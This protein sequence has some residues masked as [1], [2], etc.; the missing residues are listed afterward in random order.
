MDSVIVF[1]GKVLVLWGGFVPYIVIGGDEHSI[2][3][4]PVAHVN[5]PVHCKPGEQVRGVVRKGDVRQVEVRVWPSDSPVTIKVCYYYCG[6]IIITSIRRIPNKGILK[7][8]SIARIILPKKNCSKA[9]SIRKIR[10]QK[11]TPTIIITITTTTTSYTRITTPTTRTIPNTHV[12][13]S[14]VRKNTHTILTTIKP[15]SISVISH[16]HGTASLSK[17]ISSSCF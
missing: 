7:T 15:V 4:R 11:L 9:F 12:I 13:S 2:I 8:L 17:S 10:T 14:I 6:S 16:I 3:L 5:A 1:E